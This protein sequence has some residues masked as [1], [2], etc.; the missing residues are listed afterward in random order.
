MSI[1][2]APE[3]ALTLAWDPDVSRLHA[4]LEISG[5]QWMLIDDGLSRNGSFVNGER[6]T[7]RRR[8]RDGD[9]LRFR[10][11]ARGSSAR[12][13]RARSH[14]HRRRRGQRHAPPTSPSPSA[15]C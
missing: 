13:C 4:E 5:G 3:T 11:D 12:R 10:R 9:A 2:R 7:G 1:G 6:L 14:C 15:G 8:L